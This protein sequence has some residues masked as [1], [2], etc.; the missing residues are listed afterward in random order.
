MRVRKYFSIVLTA[1]I[2]LLMIPYK[3]EVIVADEHETAVFPNGT[4]NVQQVA[5]G[6]YSHSGKNATDIVP[7]GDVYAPFSGTIRYRDTAW[8]FVWLESDSEVY[9]ADGTFGKMCV[10]FMHDDD[11]SDLPVGKHINQYQAFYQKGEK[12]PPG[13]DMVTGPHVHIIVYRGGYTSALADGYGKKGNSYIYDAFYLTSNTVMKVS[14]YDVSKWR[15]D[16]FSKPQ[17]TNVSASKTTAL[18]GDTITLSWG[19]KNAGSV[20]LHVWKDGQPE[21]FSQGQGTNTSKA[22]TLNSPGT[23]EARLIPYS[24]QGYTG[25]EGNYSSVTIYVFGAVTDQWISANKTT[26]GVGEQ[27]TFSFGATNAFNFCLGIDKDGVGRI[28]T[29]DCGSNTSFTTSFSE[30]G[31]Y[32]VYASCSNPACYVDTSRVTVRVVQSGSEMTSGYDRVLP[33]G[34]YI[35]ANTQK[36]DNRQFYYLDISGKE[37]AN[38]QN[39]CIYNAEADII[40]DCDVWTITYD[41]GFYRIRQKGTNFDL[42]VEG[43]SLKECTNVQV[44]ENSSHYDHVWAIS[45]N[46]T[47][48]GY[49]IQSKINGFSLNVQDNSVEQHSNVDVYS[50]NDSSHQSW[51]FIPYKP[52]QPIDEGKYVILS[53]LA[54]GWE[55][56]VSGNSG[57]IPNGTNVQLWSAANTESQYNSFNL[58]K[59]DN[60]YYKIIHAASGKALT[61]ENADTVFSRNIAVWADNT[62]LNQQWAIVKNG[63]GYSII[64]RLSGMA[65]DVEKS[66]IADGTNIS[67]YPRKTE[68]NQIWSFVPAEYS[69]EYNANGG[70]GAPNAQIKYYMT[71]ITLSKTQPTR[72]GYTFQGWATSSKATKAE[73]KPGA[74]YSE[75]ENA[76]L[77]AVWKAIPTPTQTPTMTPTNTP[78]KAPV[79]PT[80]TQKATPV[81]T[82]K[83]VTPTPTKKVSPTPTKKVT[84]TKTPT[85]VPTKTPTKSPT[86]VPTKKPTPTQAPV[87]SDFVERL[88][89]CALNRAS[90][91][92]GKKFWTDEVTSGRRT[93]GDCARF[94]LLEAPEFMN[95]HLTV[96]QFVET[97][98]KTFFDRASDAAGKAGWVEAINTGAKTRAEVVNDFIESTEW[99]NVCAKYSVKPGA[100]YHKATIAS[101]N[102][103]DFATRL[104]TCCLKRKADEEGVKYWSLALTNLEQTGCSAAREFFT[105]A[106]F[107]SFNTTPEEYVRRLY[108]T[109][110]DRTADDGEVTYWAAKIRSNEMSRLAVL[111][112]FGSSE[113]FSNIC[114]KYGIDRGTI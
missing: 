50:A 111:Q 1:L 97:L 31:T 96:D 17:V 66:E 15:Y 83:A 70:S 74:K 22:I 42:T 110:M 86:K 10:G 16:A 53:S 12:E 79:T 25:T 105:G 45:P 68:L 4:V 13:N 29:P 80:P 3:R 76:V 49:R 69:V 114:A 84:P 108:T 48:T 62:Q 99:C 43:R 46:A 40:P 72:K 54:N 19:L 73:Y 112:F 24:G 28:A 61:M 65:I 67:Q 30:P 51:V 41:S 20:W 88:Y 59:L 32:T 9:W 55:M 36:M 77:Y 39:V 92:G 57:D 5:F 91:P 2:V 26:V 11:I 101:P 23:Y 21:F 104:Y 82:K 89:T 87:F 85:I 98:Y 103:I 78:T 94:F 102:A 58:Q 113:E 90:E 106:E 93:G 107:K 56:D 95:R 8:N 34:D 71:D 6:G 18:A 37:T 109:F 44:W 38:G 52:S 64:S 60:G 33:D 14:G 75:D 35:I 63:T 100:K 81:P 47:K 27:V 7:D